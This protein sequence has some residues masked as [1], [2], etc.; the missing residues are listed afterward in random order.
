MNLGE[1]LNVT[2]RILKP[3]GMRFSEAEMRNAL[4]HSMHDISME[5]EQ[6]TQI[7]FVDM[8]SID[9]DNV[10]YPPDAFPG[11]I[12]RVY[13]Y[14]TGIEFE[15]LGSL[16]ATALYPEWSQR[17]RTYG[18]R[19]AVY[20]PGSNEGVIALRPFRHGVQQLAI[21]YVLKTP[22]MKKVTDLPWKGL[23]QEGSQTLAYCAA[24]ELSGLPQFY[25]VYQEKLRSLSGLYS[26][27]E[28]M[29]V[30]PMYEMYMG[31]RW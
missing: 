22:Y 9:N 15:L 8:A 23:L 12:K 17:T 30:N 29:S 14:S 26:D 16:D 11:L 1:L 21:N 18:S 4:N 7:H 20:D 19:M 24:Y 6:P 2:R 31:R 3:T 25:Q 28:V 13:D 5:I 27:Q 10:P